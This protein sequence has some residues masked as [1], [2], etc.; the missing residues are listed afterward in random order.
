[1]LMSPPD[2]EHLTATPDED[3]L[4]FSVS[5]GAGHA[6][7][8]SLLGW[9]PEATVEAE[10]AIASSVPWLSARACRQLANAAAYQWR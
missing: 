5:A 2:I 7:F 4:A 10:A 1:M 9:L 6:T 3:V 8:L